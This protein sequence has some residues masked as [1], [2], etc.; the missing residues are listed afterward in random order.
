MTEGLR[1]EDQA[2]EAS[3]VSFAVLPSYSLTSSNW[4]DALAHK[5]PTKMSIS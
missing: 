3:I 1:N 4:L 2:Q 5:G